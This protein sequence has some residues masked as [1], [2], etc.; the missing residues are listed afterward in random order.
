LSIPGPAVVIGATGGI[1]AALVRALTARG[2][3]VHALSRGGPDRIDI[4]DE[5]SVAAAAARIADGPA[6]RLV[7][8][9]TGLLHEPGLM[10]ER[11][12]RDLDAGQLARSY[13][14]NAIGP[15]LVAKH[16]LPLL[17]RDGRSVFA[18]L[19]AR[20]GS[21]GDNRLG[22]WTGYR[23]AKAALA[24]LVR[25]LAIETT[26]RAPDAICVALHPGTVAT[27]LSQP[28][29]RNLAEGQLTMPDD[30][31]SN[32]LRV[33]DALTVADSGHVLAWDGERIAP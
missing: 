14:V 15:A 18:A 3:A 27:A 9:A 33:I 19:G 11:S 2:G 31:A 1:G 7:I 8:V 13:A 30:A 5:A 28:F 22:G 25:N 4:L 17:P 23:M 29:R 21:I 20:V 12:I 26:R 10:P 32:L 16:F 6:P 24:M